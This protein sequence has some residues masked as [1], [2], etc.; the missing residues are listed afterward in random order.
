MNQA[1]LS[2]A[3]LALEYCK[4]MAEALA[5]APKPF[6]RE[7]LRY[8]PR[9]YITIADIKADPDSDFVDEAYETGAIYDS[10]T[11]E[12]YE[13][14]RAD[15]ARVL[16]EH[17]VFLDT[18]VEDMRFSDTPVAVSLAELL[19]DI[20][21]CMADFAATMAQAD[22][23]LVPEILADL[24]YRFESYL[25]DTLCRALK[26]ANYIYYNADLDTPDNE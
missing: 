26:A 7:V 18:S 25:S 11:E 4:V 20:F 6:L 10:I 3:T 15:M 19:A 17:D 13:G 16:G 9:F 1:A 22:D 14:A 21:Q 12:Q 5:T 24:K 2:L 23:T 8:I